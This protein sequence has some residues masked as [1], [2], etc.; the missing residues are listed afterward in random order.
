MIFDVALRVRATALDAVAMVVGGSPPMSA[1]WRTS[2]DGH[3]IVG[4]RVQ[5]SCLAATAYVIGD[6][7]RD[8]A[9]V[10]V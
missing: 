1:R 3:L 2:W 6:D 7:P 8:L 10:V 4:I 5:L 9:Q